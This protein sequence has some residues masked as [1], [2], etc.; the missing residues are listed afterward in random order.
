MAA[1]RVVLALLVL[2][3]GC[4]AAQTAGELYCGEQDNCYDLLGV[5]RSADA[6]T[7][8]KAYRKLALKWHPDKN[9]QA[10]AKERFTK[11]SRAHEVLSDDKLRPAYDYGPRLDERRRS[12]S[13]FGQQGPAIDV[14]ERLRQGEVALSC[15][16]DC[17]SQWG[18]LALYC[19]ASVRLLAFL[20]ISFRW[21]YHA[22]YA[23]K[24][25]LW[26]VT[27]GVLLFFSLLQYINQHWKYNS[28][29]RCIRIF[30]ALADHKDASRVRTLLHS[31]CRD[32]YQQKFQ[33]RVN[34]RLEAEIAAHKGKLNKTE[35]DILRQRVEADV[36][37][38]EVQ[39]S[40]GDFSK[41]NFWSLVVF[42]FALLPVTITR[43]LCSCAQWHW[44]FT[45][46]KAGGPESAFRRN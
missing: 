18:A 8:K 29:M 30:A 16:C 15:D 24:T 28:M 9:K 1:Q 6:A 32:R 12:E 7:I 44:R 13:V 20:P 25:P 11:I 33:K 19:S 22:V 38:N 45:V 23:P 34:E 35:R 17:G 5:D 10:G 41:P 42:R 3:W 43:W 40:G 37:E 2:P 27:T 46:K 36:I 31:P 21:Y 14:R 4:G 26:A 39:L